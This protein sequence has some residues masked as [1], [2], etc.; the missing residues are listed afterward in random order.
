MY[1]DMP[2][3]EEEKAGGICHVVS[4]VRLPHWASVDVW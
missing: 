3:D 4:F 2:V 1:E